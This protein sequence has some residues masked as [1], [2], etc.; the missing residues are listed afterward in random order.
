MAEVEAHQK[1]EREKEE[2]NEKWDEQNAQLVDGHERLVQELTDDYEYKLQACPLAMCLF[3]MVR[4]G[5][6]PQCHVPFRLQEERAHV[7]SLK[8]EKEQL[9]QKIEAS[10][11]ACCMCCCATCAWCTSHATCYGV[12][13]VAWRTF[14]V[15]GHT[16]AD[17]G[18]RGRGDRG[19]Q[20]KVRVEGKKYP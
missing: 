4:R 6:S 17:R 11:V 19:A 2:L 16:P 8:L 5:S 3:G 20:G 12:F 18:R 9:I 1:M 15:T 7:E 10:H 14:Y 13:R